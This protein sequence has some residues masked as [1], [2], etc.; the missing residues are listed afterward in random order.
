MKLIWVMVMLMSSPNMTSIKTQSFLYPTEEKCMTALAE[1]LSLYE[2]K[3]LGYMENLKT[4]GYCLPFD[5]FPVKGMNY[6]QSVFGA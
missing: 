6:D 4:T 1:Y 3:S 5:A 2:S